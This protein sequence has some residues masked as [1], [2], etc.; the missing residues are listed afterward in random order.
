M[1]RATLCLLLDDLPAD[2]PVLVLATSDVVHSELP[3]ELGGLFTADYVVSVGPPTQEQRLAF[4]S[5]CVTALVTHAK[6]RTA[7][8]RRR[9]RRL[10]PAPLP[11]APP[12]AEA[13]AAVAAAAAQRKA[14]ASADLRA[15]RAFLRDALASLLPDRRWR[16]FWAQPSEEAFEGWRDAVGPHA[17]DLTRLLGRVNDG[18]IVTVTQFLAGVA[19]IPAALLAY[20]DGQPQDRDDALL[21]SRAFALKDHLESL[22]AGLDPQ[23][24]ARCD[25]AAAAL[26]PPPPMAALPVSAGGALPLL[27][28]P[29]AS[30][31]NGG[32]GGATHRSTRQRHGGG[33]GTH[34]D[35]GGGA[36]QHAPVL[37]DTR[38]GFA[39]DPEEMA[40]QVRA[41]K[42]LEEA[43][44]RA[45]QQQ[46]R[47]LEEAGAG[48][49]AN[50]DGEVHP[51]AGG[52]E[53][54]AGRAVS[55]VQMHENGHEVVVV[56][57]VA[58]DAPQ[59]H[60][61][62]AADAPPRGDA[63]TAM[64]LDF[65]ADEVDDSLT[66]QC[67]DDEATAQ[68][69]SRIAACAA[70]LAAGTEGRLSGQLLD[71]AARLGDA[72]R[73]LPPRPG[74]MAAL[75]AAECVAAMLERRE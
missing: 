44:A 41:A 7:Q 59:G 15:V 51:A 47:A 74:R 72:L 19:S 62:N 33:G 3:P 71:D 63:Q 27:M 21:V 68:V 16:D 25:A 58:G 45:Q 56:A 20:F 43:Q 23:L 14:A 55:D 34:Q 39:P 54:A 46:Q 57:H 40:R 70:R 28:P 5:A 13:E 2:M 24:V 1:L 17:M 32:S 61:G 69:P 65:D 64:Q 66:G 29:P 22:C 31:A 52:E 30:L 35:S 36:G 50:G 53:V 18:S 26:P 49:T 42:R 67:T 37:I 4:W 12:S 9:K 11:L 75:A 6:R 38:P 10:P 48:I 73:A 8:Q 60:V